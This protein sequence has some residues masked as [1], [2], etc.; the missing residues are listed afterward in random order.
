M[1]PSSIGIQIG[2]TTLPKEIGA[3][4]AAA[5]QLGYGEAWLAEDYFDLGGVASVALALT[6]TERIAVGLG[7]VAAPVRHP[8]ATAMEFATLAGA[9]PGRF[10]AGLGHGAPGWVRQMGLKPKSPLGL[11]REATSSIRQLLD[12]DEVTATGEYFDFDRIRLAHRPAASV[13]L[14]LGVHGPASLKLSGEL[15]DGT[16]LGWLSSPGYVSWARRQI[17]QGRARAGR[18]DTHELVALC[19]LS[20]STD[21]PDGAR[22]RLAQWAAPMLDGMAGSPQL[23]PSITGIDRPPGT[24]LTEFAAVGDLESCAATIGRILEAG[25]DRVVLLPNPAG[26]RTTPEMLEQMQIAAPLIETL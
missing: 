15:A 3:V 9:H 23:D 19:L 16:L 22:H 14:Y 2:A 25:A 21:N 20:T 26:L 13:P 4:V 24:Q 17:D 7:V 6:A 12:G 8:A 10:M 5:E 11:L 1:Q 18:C